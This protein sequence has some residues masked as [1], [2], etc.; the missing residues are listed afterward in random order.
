VW[1]KTSR[2][3]FWGEI[4]PF[5]GMAVLGLVISTL[6]VALVSARWDSVYA[7]TA[8]SLAAF[9]SVWVGKYFVLNDVLFSGARVDSTVDVDA[10]PSALGS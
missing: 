4:V 10:S 1:K 3:H 7:V 5:W 2:N 8:A 9:G 6:F